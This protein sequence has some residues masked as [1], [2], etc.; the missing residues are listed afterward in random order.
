MPTKFLF[1]LGLAFFLIATATHL[2]L[3]HWLDSRRFTPLDCPVS[4]DN[5]HL[6]SPPFE[7]N[8]GETYAAY[9]DLDGS[10][11]DAYQDDRCNFKKIMYP[12]WRVYRL[13]SAKSPSRELWAEHL[14]NSDGYRSNAFFASPGQYQ[15]EWDLPAAA[16]CLN[17]RHPRLS[18]S[19]DSSAYRDGVG[20]AQLCCLFLGCTGLALF[21]AAGQ[22][23]GQAKVAR[24]PGPRIFPEMPLGHVLPIPKRPPLPII[25]EMPHFGLLCGAVLWILILLFMVRTP[26][27]IRGFFVSW[28]SQNAVVWEKSPWPETLEVYVAR[29]AR[30]FINGEEVSR[31][32]LGPKLSQQLARRAEWTVYFEADPESLFMDDA[33]AM[34]TIQS[35]GARVVWITPKLRQEWQQKSPALK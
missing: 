4:L 18:V 8:L 5:R 2:F 19:T 3:D 28:K 12:E 23:F 10:V 33:F 24:V 21:V 17:P 13:G 27:T 35:C 14:K 7:I 11:D 16:P 9:L 6:Q 22:Q 30:F 26:R 31:S 34:D 32:D 20:L 25:H 29:P 15:L 1:R